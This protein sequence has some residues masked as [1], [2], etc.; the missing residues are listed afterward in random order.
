MRM[1][2]GGT[3]LSIVIPR[4]R[5][6]HPSNVSSWKTVKPITTFPDGLV[7]TRHTIFWTTHKNT[8]YVLI[9]LVHT[10]VT[11]ASLKLQ[12]AVFLRTF[13]THLLCVSVTLTSHQILTSFK[14]CAVVGWF[15]FRVRSLVF[16]QWYR[17]PEIWCNCTS[18]NLCLV[19]WWW[20]SRKCNWLTRAY[21]STSKNYC[22]GVE[23]SKGTLR[24]MRSF[25]MNGCSQMHHSKHSRA[26][27]S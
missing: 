3:G 1:P 25:F 9:S 20:M 27:Y 22:S 11:S 2:L 6:P 5:S 12:A 26:L 17:S 14:L 10:V 19:W 4:S 24:K 15:R 23:I 21:H 18:Q 8:C 16:I 7:T 13:Y